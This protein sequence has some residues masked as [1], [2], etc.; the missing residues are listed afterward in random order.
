MHDEVDRLV[1]AWGRERDDLAERSSG[2]CNGVPSEASGARNQTKPLPRL[3]RYFSGV[4]RMSQD[5]LRGFR[6]HALAAATAA[7][8]AAAMASAPAV[9]AGQGVVNTAGLQSDAGNDRFIIKYR[10]GSA[11]RTSAAALNRSLNAAANS[12]LHGQALGLKKL[13]RTATGAEVL[14][15]GKKLGRSDAEALM[16]QLA[17]DP[18]VE[19]V[20]VDQLMHPAAT[21]NDTYYTSHQWHYWEAAGGIKA[22]KAWDVTDGSGV[23]VAVLDTGITN[24]SDLNANILPGYDFISDTTVAGDGNGRD[25]N[26]ADPGDYYQ[27][28]GSSWHGTHVAG[29]VAALTGNAEILRRVNAA[30]QSGSGHGN[31]NFPSRCFIA[32]SQMEATL[33][34]KLA[35]SSSSARMTG[36]GRFRPFPSISGTKMLVSSR[37]LTSAPRRPGSAVV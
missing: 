23:V 19:Y 36:S 29:T 8:L 22:D 26:P 17:A 10:E 21:A 4:S 32:T 27:G 25:S 12:T 35:S 11:Q 31:G 15:T 37:S 13:R 18:N 24:H 7:V 5:S 20:E 6:T 2:P 28:S 34:H 1:E 14:V 16:R 9:A 3:R 30:G 33:A